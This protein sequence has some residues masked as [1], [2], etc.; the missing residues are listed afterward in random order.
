MERL[1]HDASDS[2]DI[3][4]SSTVASEAPVPAAKEPVN[5]TE[6]RQRIDNVVNQLMDKLDTS[7]AQVKN[8]LSKKRKYCRQPYYNI[9]KRI[10]EKS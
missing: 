5:R 1:L 4:L 6:I 3:D 9:R 2:M 7:V 8:S 10:V